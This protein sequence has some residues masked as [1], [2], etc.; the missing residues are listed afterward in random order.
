MDAFPNGDLLLATD[1]FLASDEP[2]P[3]AR[4]DSAIYYVLTPDGRD[5]DTLAVH[6]GGESYQTME[7][8]AWLGGGLVF[9]KAGVAAVSRDGY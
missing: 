3:G 1:M 6:P 5:L 2:A 8:E 9:G 4:R 7:G